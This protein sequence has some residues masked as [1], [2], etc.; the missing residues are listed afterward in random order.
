MEIEERMTRW[1]QQTLDELFAAGQIRFKLTAHKVESNAVG[2][3]TVRFFDSRLHS[4]TVSWETGLSFK[5]L[6]QTALLDRLREDNQVHEQN[7]E[8]VA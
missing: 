6:L 3:Y 8:L 4:V 7:W 2:E 1:A 5:D